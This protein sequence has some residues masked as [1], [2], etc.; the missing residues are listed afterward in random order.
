MPALFLLG[1]HL[2]NVVGISHMYAGMNTRKKPMVQSQNASYSF[3]HVLKHCYMLLFVL[4]MCLLGTALL[5]T[6][7]VAKKKL[8]KRAGYQLIKWDNLLP[9]SDLHALQ[10]APISKRIKEGSLADT[11]DSPLSMT[12]KNPQGAYEKALVSTRIR[13]EY[14]NR[15]IKLPGFIVPIDLVGEGKTKTFFFVPFFG[16]CLHLP[17]PP[18]N[19]IIYATFPKGYHVKD[20]HQPYYIEA[21][22]YTKR[23]KNDMATAAYT[24]RVAKIYK[25]QD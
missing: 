10:K 7:A 4:G 1:W 13:K 19:Q 16:A 12:L 6:P 8:T 5:S 17:P 18:P 25:Y 3:R 23:I 22:L 11:I 21:R 24:A 2:C 14:N 9:A 20:L 15:K